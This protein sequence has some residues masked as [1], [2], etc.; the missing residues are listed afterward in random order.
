MKTINFYGILFC[1]VLPFLS[2]CA[3]VSS[4]ANTGTAKKY[5]SLKDS[6]DFQREKEIFKSRIEGKSLCPDMGVS[7]LIASN[8]ATPSKDCLYP[9][10]KLV[11]DPGDM[12]DARQLKQSL[13]TIKVIQVT[14]SGFIVNAQYF[15]LYGRVWSQ[16]SSDRAAFIQKTD[17]SNIVDGAYLDPAYN[18]DLYEYTGVR[19]Y[20]TA[21]GGSNT[22][23]SFRKIPQKELADAKKDLKTYGVFKEFFIENKLWDM[24]KQLEDQQLNEK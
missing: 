17:E 18:W 1:F 6:A 24:L 13:N 5:E 8:N 4:I 11:V 12:I 10:S 22:V 20:Q 3:T 19:Q 23:H 16:R 9:A 7:D 21:I 15:V 2:G 14:P